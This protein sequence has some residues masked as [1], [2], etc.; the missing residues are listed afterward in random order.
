M[1]RTKETPH[2]T[3]TQTFII[4]SPLFQSRGASP[5]RKRA[6]KAC[7]LHR[8]LTGIYDAILFFW[9]IKRQIQPC[10][11]YITPHMAVAFPS[12]PVI[13]YGKTFAD[14]DNGGHAYTFF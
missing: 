6:A 3:I 8:K 5:R 10:Q 12:G 9:R 7:N 11:S 1:V 14:F 2:E 4:C 13:E